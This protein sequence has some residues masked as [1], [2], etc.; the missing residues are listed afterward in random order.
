MERDSIRLL[1]EPGDQGKR[2]DAFLSEKLESFSRTRIQ[3]LIKTGQVD[4]SSGP[5]RKSNVKIQ[6]GEWIE[7]RLPPPLE[8]AIQ[9]EDLPLEILHEDED[10]AVVFKPAGM[11][12]HP[13]QSRTSGTLVNALHYHLE[14]LSGV[15]G[16][17]RPGIVHRLDRVTSGILVVAKNDRAHHSLT[18]QFK[19]R[20][21]K[22]TY[23]AIG[24]GNPSESSGVIR[25]LINRHPT[26]RQ[27]MILG[28]RSGRESETA[29]ET[30]AQSEPVYGFLL[31]PHTGRTH[32]IRVHL[33]RIHC[34]IILDNLYGYEPKRWPFPK[35]NPWLR[36]YPGI[37][38]HAE[39]LEFDHPTTGER[40]SFRIDPPTEF[41][42]LWRELFGEEFD[43]TT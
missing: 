10:L 36:D 38:L 28:G 26:R 19:Q 23:R 15:G 33:E 31:H 41:V 7:V 24:L 37:L 16:V 14:N 9:G 20:S 3:D 42:G 13:T 5:I 25:G 6:K 21:V 1:T 22:K 18:Q 29:Y 34:P 32:Q 27:R 4:S 39:Q 11:P 17:L 30:V 40:M 43:K 8:S 35:L 2:I 12:T